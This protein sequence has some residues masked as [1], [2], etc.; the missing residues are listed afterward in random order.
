MSQKYTYKEWKN[1]VDL[2]YE[3][4]L[5]WSKQIILSVLKQNNHP[6]VCLSWGKDSIVM[7][8]IIR[9]YC[10]KVSVVFANTLIEYPET[11]KYRDMMLK[12]V[13]PNMVYYETQP[14]KKFSECIK[15]YGYPHKRNPD[16]DKT[17]KR[18]PKCCI[19]LKERP[20]DNKIKE[21]NCDVQFIGLQTT[22]SMNRRRLFMRLGA[23]YFNKT[24]NINVCLPLAI[25]NDKDILRYAKENNIPLNPL[26][27]IMN[28][29]GCMF[30]TG[31]KNWKAVMGKYNKKMLSSILLKKE[32]QKSIE[33]CYI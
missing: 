6:V 24:R 16:Q 23:Y 3:D 11:Y 30:C 21:L 29:T 17:N 25:W 4:K 1:W 14:I 19:Y 2:S 18:Q 28:R 22:E 15:L 13:F 10:K 20:L 9:Q 5:I 8:H 12:E 33:D 32:G 27:K 7:L 31:F 26:Y